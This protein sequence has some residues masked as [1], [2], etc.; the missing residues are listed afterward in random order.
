MLITCHGLATQACTGHVEGTTREQKTGAKIVGVIARKGTTPK[1][2][3]VAVGVVNSVSFS[4]VGGTT[5][6]VALRLNEVGR[7]LL[8]QFYNVPVTLHLAGA[9]STF[10]VGFKYPRIS[11]IIAYNV[12]YTGN[13]STVNSLTISKLPAHPKVTIRC[14][15][16]GCPFSTENLRP[17]TANEDLTHVFADSR[18]NAGTTV[19]VAI[20]APEHVGEVLAITMQS[21][22]GPRQT[23][24]C[25]P[26]GATAPSRCA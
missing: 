18:L 21:S 24:L 16:L 25:Q 3:T 20:Q 26:P 13:I 6:A 14:R 7:R 10:P 5:A 22:T 12:S 2:R 8:E 9:S 11:S 15:G 17:R 23:N 19:V 1:H 4:V